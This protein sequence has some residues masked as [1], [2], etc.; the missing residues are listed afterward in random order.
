MKL[1]AKFPY[2]TYGRKSVVPSRFR[3][4]DAKDAI[5]L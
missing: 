1:P 5:D 4:S 2:T 3:V